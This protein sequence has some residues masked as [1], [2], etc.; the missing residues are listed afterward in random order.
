[1]KKAA[2]PYG[3]AWV[4]A[5]YEALPKTSGLSPATIARLT[6]EGGSPL[7]PSLAAALT[8]DRERASIDGERV[9]AVKFGDWAAEVL[10]DWAD[11]LKKGLARTFR[12]PCMPLASGSESGTFLYL[13]APDEAG[14]YPV[15]TV[16]VD[17]VPEWSIAFGG[18]DAWLASDVGKPRKGSDPRLADHAK[19]CFGGKKRARMKPVLADTFRHDFVVFGR[20]RTALDGAALRSVSLKPAPTTPGF[21][22]FFPETSD[23]TLEDCIARLGPKEFLEVSV[24]DGEAIVRGDVVDFEL[25][26]F[27]PSH[28]G[29]LTAIKDWLW[30]VASGGGAFHFVARE[31]G[32]PINAWR[33]AAKEQRVDV[34]RLAIALFDAIVVG[35]EYVSIAQR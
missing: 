23:R 19:R 29:K 11:A 2:P 27:V 10:P 20:V 5:L 13:G 28:L 4:H 16:D 15:V 17:D 3:A 6:F 34:Q 18:Y 24:I 1:M 14:E 21:E 30:T 7:P 35:A 25:K 26:N 31:N 33:V 22:L 9:R 12:A 8:H 32:R